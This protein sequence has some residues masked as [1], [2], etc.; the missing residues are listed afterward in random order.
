ME[1]VYQWCAEYGL[2]FF[3]FIHLQELITQIA[4]VSDIYILKEEI[5]AF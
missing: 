3:S 4:F 5:V 1:I 2:F